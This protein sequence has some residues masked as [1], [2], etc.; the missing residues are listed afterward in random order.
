MVSWLQENA[1]DGGW[2]FYQ[3]MLDQWQQILA[4]GGNIGMN[5]FVSKNQAK[6]HPGQFSRRLPSFRGPASRDLFAAKDA[7][8]LGGTVRMGSFSKKG[9]SNPQE[10][11]E[12][13]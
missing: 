11:G 10:R 1:N 13:P 3:Q 4:Q 6:E 5:V 7:D 12:G 9:S 8:A 2:S